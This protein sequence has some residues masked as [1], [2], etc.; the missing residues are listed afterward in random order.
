MDPPALRMTATRQWFSALGYGNGNSN[1]KNLRADGG[2]AWSPP[3]AGPGVVPRRKQCTVSK[4]KLHKGAGFHLI[5]KHPK[6]LIP[7]I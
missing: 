4:A 2:E 3:L 1:G 7:E 5:R 6:F